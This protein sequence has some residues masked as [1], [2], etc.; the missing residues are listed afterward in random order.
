MGVDWL[1]GSNHAINVELSQ[2]LYEQ[3]LVAALLQETGHDFSIEWV[4]GNKVLLE[5]L[6]G[7]DSRALERTVRDIAWVVRDLGTWV[8]LG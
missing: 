6:I 2:R 8:A 3:Q 7:A 4:L 1:R 5:P